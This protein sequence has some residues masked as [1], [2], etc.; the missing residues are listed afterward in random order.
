MVRSPDQSSDDCELELQNVP[1][2]LPACRK[3]TFLFVLNM[4]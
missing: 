2:Y 1:A 3:P 4:S